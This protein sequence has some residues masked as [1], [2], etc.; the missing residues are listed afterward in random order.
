MIIWSN[1]VRKVEEH[2]NLYRDDKNGIAWIEDG[3]TGLGISVHSNIDSCGSISGMKALGYW[4]KKDRTA[5]SHG[6][7]Y[8]IDSFVCDKDNEMEM[9]VADEC[10]C[11]GCIERRMKE[12]IAFNSLDVRLFILSVNEYCCESFVLKAIMSSPFLIL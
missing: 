5:R 3:R 7:I 4:G 12:A 6:W 8:N 10:M 11:Q 2:V 9:I 1:L